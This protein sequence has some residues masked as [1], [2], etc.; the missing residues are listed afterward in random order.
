MS[1]ETVKQVLTNPFGTARLL[2][3]FSTLSRGKAAGITNEQLRKLY[4][5]L[6]NATDAEINGFVSLGNKLVK[7]EASCKGTVFPKEKKTNS[8]LNSANQS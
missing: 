3:G 6:Q 7:G 4:P 1:L 2:E 5:D 8:N